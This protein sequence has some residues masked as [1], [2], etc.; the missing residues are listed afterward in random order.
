MAAGGPRI[1]DLISKG[2]FEELE[3]YFSKHPEKLNVPMD[4]QGNDIHE[5]NPPLC[6]AAHMANNNQKNP[7]YVAKMRSIMKLKADPNLPDSSGCSPL[8]IAVSHCHVESLRALLEN[9]DTK[10]DLVCPIHIGGPQMTAWASIQS[11]IPKLEDNKKDPFLPQWKKQSYERSIKGAK[12]C[13]EMFVEHDRK[14]CAAA[15]K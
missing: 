1:I 3:Q 14:K 4:S 10:T 8:H 13:V 5:L 6:F 9:S 15:K 2:T 11:I 7:S 12:E